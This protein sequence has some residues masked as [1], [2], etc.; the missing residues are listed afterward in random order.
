MNLPVVD[1]LYTQIDMFNMA[2]KIKVTDLMIAL[3][4]FGYFEYQENSSL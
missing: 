1:T 4:V 2:V 3:A